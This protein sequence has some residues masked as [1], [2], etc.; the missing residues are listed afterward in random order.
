[1][2][3]LIIGGSGT[4]ST[5]VTARAVLTLNAEVFV[6][7]RGNR[8]DEL[9]RAC[10]KEAAR[11]GCAVK[12]PVYLTGDCKNETELS[13][14]IS[15]VS[16]TQERFDA[17]ADFIAFTKE[18]VERDVRIFTGKTRQYVFISSASAYHKPL[19]DYRITEGTALANPFW[20]YSRNK[21]ECEDFLMNAYRTQGFPVTIVRPSHTYGERSVPLG[22]HG[23]N[24]SWQVV[25]RM[26]EG[27]PVI[28]H[29]DG[30]SLWT[31]THN[32]DFARA[33]CG[34]LCNANAVGEAVNITSDESLT[35]NQIYGCVAAAVNVPLKAVHISSEFLAAAAKLPVSGAPVYDF[36]GTLIGDKSNTVVFDN[37][38]LKRLVNGFYSH[39]R[40]EDG[41]RET[42]RHI[43]EHPELQRL[44]PDFDAWC[45]KIIGARENALAFLKKS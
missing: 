40:F 33:F 12:T 13:R 2:K 26:I 43:L 17:V 5:A 23:A 18:D 15:S 3:I 6:L 25:R 19:C 44:D 37:T 35:W 4:I 1:M 34:L 7:N 27:K 28:I 45:D 38:K 14:L 30:T 22:L 29:G 24:G 42:V 39:I 16:D 32:R 20:Q 11:L 10:E 21:I 41:V 36:E 9:N 31:M 8:N